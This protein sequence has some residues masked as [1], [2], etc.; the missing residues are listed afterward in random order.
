MS[1]INNFKE[2][3]AWQKANELTVAVYKNFRDCKDFSFRD[4]IQRASVSI[5]NNIAEGFERKGDKEFKRFLFIAQGSCA[6]VRSMLSLAEQLGYISQD[7]SFE[8]GSLGLEITKMLS[9][10][11]KRLQD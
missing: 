10:F 7:K 6:E 1:N 8:L 9:V 5:M 4:Q 11:I 3:I 2:I